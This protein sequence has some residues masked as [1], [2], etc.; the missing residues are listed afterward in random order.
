ML[1]LSALESAGRVLMALAFWLIIGLALAASIGSGLALV[2]VLPWPEIAVIW[3]G[4][5]LP[6]AGMWAQLSLT[7]LLILL[8]FFLPAQARVARLE[9]SHR[10]F[11][12]GIEDVRHAY[13][14]AHAADRRGVFSLS[15]EFESMRARM[16]HLSRHPDLS[17]LEPE[18]LALAAQM[19]HES[20]ELARVYSESRVNRARTFLSQ[21]QEEAERFAERLDLA[22]QTCDALRR[23]LAD[24]EASE[25]ANHAQL[26][27]LEAD[28]R[29][30]LPGLGYDVDD[31]REQNV[32]T[33]T[34]RAPN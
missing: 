27:R 14:A 15:S 23:W 30:I 19:S 25:R 22:R 17:D 10:S 12:I 8:C 7:A 6:G 26:R 21:R 34:H 28:L 1:H 33:L 32:V 3:N 9:R 29:E 5:P 11:H 16:E 20:R 4:A 24:I 13:Q 31:M 2:G 18:L